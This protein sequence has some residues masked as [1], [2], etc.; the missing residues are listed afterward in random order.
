[1]LLIHQAFVGPSE[2]GGTRHFELAAHLVKRGGRAAIICSDISY[3]TGASVG[4]RRPRF[5]TTE[6]IAGVRICRV[7]TYAGY[8]RSYAHRLLAF[9]GFSL[10]AFIAAARQPRPDVV[11]GTSPPPFQGVAA[12]LAARWHG[13]P[14]IYEIRDLFWDYIAQTQG[15][16]VGPVSRL[17]RRLDR[18]LCRRAAAVVVNSPGFIPYVRDAG[19]P[20]ERIALVSNGTD[21]DL[22]SPARAD[23]AAWRPFG[24]EG[25][26]IV[27]YAGALGMLNGL[28][29]LIDAAKLLADVP[30]LRVCLMGD[31]KEK[32]NLIAHVE[33]MGLTNVVFV[34]AQPKT[35]MPALIGSADVCVATLRDLPILRTVYP[36]KVFDY[37]AAGRPVVLAMDGEIR[38]VIEAAGAGWCVPPGSA[39]ELA[40]AIRGLY[41]DRPAAEAAGARGRAYVTQHFDREALARQFIEVIERTVAGE[42]AMGFYARRVKGLL[43]VAA[44]AAALVVALPIIAALALLVRIVL[45]GP[46]FFIQERPGL[47]GRPFRLI[48]FRSMSAA[49]NAAGRLLSEEERL[50]RFG[51]A[52]RRSSLDELP[53]LLNVLKRDMSLVGPR[54]LLMEYLPRYTAEQARRHEVRPGITGWAEVN[55]R[56]ALSWE[57]RFRLDVWYVD[58]LSFLLDLRTVGRTLVK[59]VTGDGVNEAG[60]VT[61]SPFQGSP[62]VPRETSHT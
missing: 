2:P 18:A 41:E 57:E 60:H 6:E 27:L 47:G 9:A 48:K 55:G 39:V 49:R 30:D 16:R 32:A 44:G 24:C 11:I 59:V 15:G 10:S 36:N 58:H 38:K 29:T 42:R 19:V 54:P 40:A 45:G 14:F 56:N 37:L 26:F 7:R 34:P 51:R 3:L 25:A 52:L 17:G 12:Y 61:R 20:E 1:M 23:R 31:G 5:S 13:V 22:F 53:E 28:E 4:A 35:A 50:G 43:D 46:V 62:A 33:R 8:H 21:T